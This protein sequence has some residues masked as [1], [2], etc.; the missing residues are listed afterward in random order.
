[1]IPE[2]GDGKGERAVGCS[3]RSSTAVSA[4][5]TYRQ[6]TANGDHKTVEVGSFSILLSNTLIE[7]LITH[8]N[9]IVSFSSGE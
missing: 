3:T 1:M 9:L 6:R 8:F 4:G 2:G 5:F 7:Y